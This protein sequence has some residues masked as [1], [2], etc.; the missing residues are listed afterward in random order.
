M[1][2]LNMTSH[3]GKP[4]LQKR[5]IRFS[6]EVIIRHDPQDGDTDQEKTL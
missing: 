2:I 3:P 4:Q 6:T 5:S 1:P